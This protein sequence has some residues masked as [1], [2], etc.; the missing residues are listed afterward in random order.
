M[1][2]DAFQIRLKHTLHRISES[3]YLGQPLNTPNKFKSPCSICNKNVTKGQKALFCHS[4]DKHAHIKCNA[5]SEELY[6]F[7][8]TINTD[9]DSVWSCLLCTM[10][11]YYEKFP[12]TLCD[13]HELQKIN[14]SDNMSVFDHLSSED[15]VNETDLYPSFSPITESEDGEFSTPEL[16]STKYYTSLEFQ[17]LQLKDRLNIFHSN[18]NGLESKLELLS[19]F[20]SGSSSPLDIIGITETSELKDISFTSNV[21]LDG[22]KLFH[23]PTNSSKGG[24]C[25]YINEQF[26][27]FERIELNAQNDQFQ[28]TWAEIKNKKVRILLLEVCIEVLINNMI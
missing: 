1:V 7:Y 3:I 19:A 25:I 15:V 8:T 22:Y 27:S 24:C 17:S 21:S 16:L 10:K 20:I 12:F 4:C 28:S 9:P 18:A 5:T 6:E 2:L 26:D 11:S 14:M 13:N 23:T